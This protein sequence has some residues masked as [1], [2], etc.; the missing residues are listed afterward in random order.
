[1]CTKHG[2]I[3]YT[4]GAELIENILDVLRKQI[5]ECDALQGVRSNPFQRNEHHP[6]VLNLTFLQFQIIQSL[7]GGT[8]SG[9]GSL[10][11]SKIR[12]EVPDRMLST[13]SILPSPKNADTV[14]EPY[15]C[16]T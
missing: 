14:V 15:A 1:M 13:F 11:M 8:G 3:D 12:E 6:V 2:I 4:E 7:G 10:V 16:F 5:E 9:L